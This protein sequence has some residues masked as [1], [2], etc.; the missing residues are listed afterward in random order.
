MIPDTTPRF[1]SHEAVHIAQ[2]VFGL[3]AGVA[4]L[5]S[6]RDQ[7]FVLD[8]F[9]GSRFVLK[10]AKSDEDRGVLE[11][12]NA[13]LKQVAARAPALAVPRLFPTRLGEDYP[14]QGP[15]RDGRITSA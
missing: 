12:Q 15:P 9:A 2:Q 1:A 5:P 7:N 6:E 11:F 13:A 3:A 10:I 4:A 8:T 14:D